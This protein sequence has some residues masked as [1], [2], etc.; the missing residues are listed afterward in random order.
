MVQN[1][2][3][4]STYLDWHTKHVKCVTELF[5]PTDTSTTVFISMSNVDI[6]LE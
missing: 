6:L 1:D 3:S 4:Y 5:S 2:Y